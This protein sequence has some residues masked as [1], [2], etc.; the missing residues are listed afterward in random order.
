MYFL[1]CEVIVVLFSSW[2]ALPSA[3]LE[4]ELNPDMFS[5]NIPSLKAHNAP[6]NDVT[7]AISPPWLQEDEELPV[8]LETKH[9]EWKLSHLVFLQLHRPLRLSEMFF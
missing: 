6:Q 3:K 9:R 5:L 1:M 7:A 2:F 8:K 4:H